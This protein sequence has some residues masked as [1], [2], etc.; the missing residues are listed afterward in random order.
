MPQAD[1]C[2]PDCKHH[3]F[4]YCGAEGTHCDIHCVCP[5]FSCIVDRMNPAPVGTSGGKIL[6]D[7]NVVGAETGPLNI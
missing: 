6:P 1:N 3:T 5:C 4:H 2:P 7:A